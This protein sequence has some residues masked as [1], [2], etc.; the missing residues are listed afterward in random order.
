MKVL[1]FSTLVA[2]GLSAQQSNTY[3]KSTVDLNGRAVVEGPQ[4]V[5]NKGPNGAEITE[6]TRSIN[7]REVPLERI[8]E[9]VLRNDAAGKVTERLTRRFDPTGNRMTPVKEII[10]EQ[11]RP[12]GGS[13][14][15]TT[16]YEGDLNG[17]LQ[18][19]ERSI[20]DV[21]RGGSSET[22][23]TVL[24]RPTLNGSME[25]V[26]KETAIR[27]KQPNGYQ[28]SITTYRKNNSG[29]FY[30][31]VKISKEHSE[32]AGQA[33][34][35][36]AEYEIGARGELRLHGQKVQKTLKRPDGS[37]DV[38]V[39]IFGQNVAGRAGSVESNSL[40]LQEQ[41]IIERRRVAP[42]TVVET[43][44]LRRTSIADSN[45]LGPLQEI[46]QTT[47]RGKCGPEK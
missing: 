34:D 13:T 18:I 17:R 21:Q 47:C 1:F 42:N 6:K 5:E 38:Q 36:S 15:Q 20:T 9:R 40:K 11:K 2:L 3:T 4:I 32:S 12:D 28:E 7:G 25:A 8:E 29:D 14:I 23:D 26:S 16:T 31:A 35:N 24:E 33:I 44:S 46:S 22:T 37:E 27:F 45:T 30:P 39:D 19:T 10:E 41:D 43:L